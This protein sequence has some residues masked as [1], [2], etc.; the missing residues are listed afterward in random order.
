MKSSNQEIG[1]EK[2]GGKKK[3]AVL[4][5]GCSTEYEVSLQSAHAVI[6]NIDTA[7]YEVLMIGIC[8]DTGQWYLYRG[9]PEM[10]PEDRWYSEETCTPVY[11]ST[12]RTVHGLCFL[13]AGKPDIISLDAALCGTWV[14][15]APSVSRIS[16]VINLAKSEVAGPRPPSSHA[17]SI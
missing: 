5:G 8:R 13:E 14:S 4:F 7:L 15:N 9:E 6:T 12:D 1:N 17:P 2:T 3:I 11:V 10:I 16:L